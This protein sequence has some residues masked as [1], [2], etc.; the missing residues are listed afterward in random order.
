MLGLENPNNANVLASRESRMT[1]REDR[2]AAAAPIL[3]FE[4]RVAIPGVRRSFLQVGDAAGQRYALV[5]E[6]LRVGGDG[7]N[8]DIGRTGCA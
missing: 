7:A 6:P 1:L 4:R 3:Q 5:V 2:E 8:G